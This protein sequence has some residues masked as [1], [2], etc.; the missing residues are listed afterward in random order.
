MHTITLD[1]E[2]LNAVDLSDQLKYV[3]WSESSKYLTL[4][5]GK[6]PYRLEAFLA[7]ELQN[8]TPHIDIG[9]Y[10]GLSALALSCDPNQKVVTYDVRDWIP[11]DKELTVKT[12][13]NIEMRL[14]DCC[15]EIEELCKAKLI[16]LDIDPHDGI[17]E[18]NI[19]QQLKKHGFKGILLL[20]DINLNANM[21]AFWDSITEQKIDV[22]EYG[23][24]SGTG[25]VI[26][27]PTNYQVIVKN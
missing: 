17:E 1:F 27:D 15:R 26:F 2:T 19:V 6:E 8:S 12:K 24:W 14:L 18:R 4:D 13:P 16:L 10:T 22:T 5:A 3:E 20:D 11:D 9:T 21:K 25:L 7:K 23:H